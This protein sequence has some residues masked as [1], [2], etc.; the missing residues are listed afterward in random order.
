MN[1]LC[2]ISGV[3]LGVV[4]YRLGRWEG[5]KGKVLFPLRHPK[6][7]ETADTGLLRQIERY[8]GKSEKGREGW[9]R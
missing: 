9:T 3:V 2:L 7:R 8:D 6:R 5:E 1:V 4:I